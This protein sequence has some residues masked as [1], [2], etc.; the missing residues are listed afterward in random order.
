M[1]HSRCKGPRSSSRLYYRSWSECHAQRA[2]VDLISVWAALLPSKE[3]QTAG[4]T[5]DQM[6]EIIKENK[7]VSTYL[8][9]VIVSITC[10]D[11]PWNDESQ[12]K[13]LIFSARDHLGVYFIADYF[14]LSFFFLF[15]MQ[16][17]NIAWGEG[18]G[19]VKFIKLPLSL[20]AFHVLYINICLRL[21]CERNTSVCGLL[22][23]AFKA[24]GD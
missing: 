24:W 12:F 9:Y 17:Q 13:G 18:R 15:F 6:W 11:L 5:R 4:T 14:F 16:R 19:K 8:M 2:Q 22:P 10:V 20:I 1:L 7:F 3:R 23:S 21:P